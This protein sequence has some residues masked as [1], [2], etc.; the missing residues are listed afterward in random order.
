MSIDPDPTPRLTTPRLL[1]RGARSRDYAA[2]AD[3][4]RRSRQHLQ[5]FEPRWSEADLAPHVFAARI[6]RGREEARAGTDF[7]FLVFR[8]AD[9]REGC[10]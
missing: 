4:R 5:P 8:R 9:R 6:R 10:L 3:L 1:L 2:W 7:S